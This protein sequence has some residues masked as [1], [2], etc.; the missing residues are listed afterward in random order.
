[1]YPDKPKEFAQNSREDVMFEI[2]RSLPDTYYVFHSFSIV[3]LVDGVLYESETDFVIFNQ[4]KGIMC[5]EAKAG[6]V[7][8]ENGGWKYGSGIE[9]SHD[10]PYNQADQNKWKLGQYMKNNGLGEIYKRCKLVHAVWFPSIPKTKFDGVNLPSEADMHITLTQES[11]EDIEKA[12]SDIFDYE[13]PCHVK[14]LL[15]QK[16]TEILINKVLAPSFNLISLSEMKADHS[17]Q[18]FKLMLKEQVALLN[19][20]DEQNSAVINGMAGTGKTVMAIEKARRHADQGERVLFLCY[21]YFLKEHLQSVYNHEN[22]SFYTIDGLACKLCNTSTP[23]YNRLQEVLSDM[24]GGEFPYQH[25]IIDEGQDF[26]KNELDEINIVT[27]LKE[28]VLAD[29]EKNGTFYLFYDKNQMVQSNKIPEYILDADCKLTLYKNSRNTRNIAIT[30]LRLL[31]TQ[32]KPKLAEGILEGDSPELYLAADVENTVKVLNDII[33][34]YWSK[35]YKSIQI[36][37][38]KTEEH[39]IISTECSTGVY[40][41]KRKKIPFTTCRKFKGL[42]ADAI[43]V[44]DMDYEMMRLGGEQVLYVGSSRARYQLSMIVQMNDIECREFLEELGARKSRKPGK[45]IATLYNA[46]YKEIK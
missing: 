32:K 45:A 44:V 30:S 8:Y 14:N 22:I 27:L 20:L 37:S 4:Q 5:I 38:C 9:M 15:S 41:Y 2:L 19:Y 16:D 46:K 12:I 28:N 3:T 42:E 18:V 11:A 7:K 36:L 40:L 21:N 17:R 29:E 24:Y 10:G 43:I 39:S 35:D 13:L 34:D 1:M 26:G 6:Q 33:E 31:G 23:D 25:V